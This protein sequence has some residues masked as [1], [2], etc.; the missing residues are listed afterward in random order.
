MQAVNVSPAAQQT[1]RA[2]FHLDPVAM[3]P[4]QAI[5]VSPELQQVPTNLFH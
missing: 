5:N 3:H 4:V 1:P 2:L